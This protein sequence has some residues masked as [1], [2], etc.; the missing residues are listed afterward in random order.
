MMRKHSYAGFI[1]LEYEAAEEP[2]EAIPKW[3]GILRKAVG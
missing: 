3:L 1:T 2:L